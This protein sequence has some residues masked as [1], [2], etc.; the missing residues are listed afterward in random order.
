MGKNI[1]KPLRRT[2]KRAASFIGSSW[3]RE[4]RDLLAQRFRSGVRARSPRWLLLTLMNVRAPITVKISGIPITVRTTTPDLEVAINCLTGEFDRLC[5][6][7]PVLHHRLIIDAG[8][9]IGTAAIAFAKRYPNATIVTLEPNTANYHILVRNTAT[10][11]NIVAINSAL[12]PEPGVSA[13]YNRGTGEWGFTLIEKAAD[14]PT[15]PIE[16]VQCITV[17]QIINQI[18]SDGIDI[19]K[20]DI[21][22]GEYALLSRNVGW[23][24]KTTG[25]CIELHDRIVPGCSMVWQAATAGRHNLPTDGEKHISLKAA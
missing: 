3:P 12:A 24:D 7:I 25:I 10:W 20:I 19:L 6:A 23:I 13:L 8:G 2:L 5:A 15:S 9:Y 4:T 21:E 1:G 18:G 22:G 11:P 17:D 14:C 16:T